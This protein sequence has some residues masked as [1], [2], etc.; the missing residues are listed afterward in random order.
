MTGF[1]VLIRLTGSAFDFSQAQTSGGDLRFAKSDNT[2]L[3]YEIERW[4]PAAGMAEVW[5]KVDTVLGNDNTHAITM[6]WGNPNVADSSNGAAVFDTASGFQGV[7]HLGEAGNTVAKDATING[8]N[9]TL[10]GMTAA[11]SVPGAIG[12]ARNFDGASGYIQMI[13][14]A[15]GKLNF[16]QNGFY[17][18]SAWVCADTLDFGTDSTRAGTI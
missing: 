1:P 6:Y 4:D 3:P 17:A 9:G 2:P 12:I 14:T 13:G 18:V 11:S 5:V 7:W 10:Y 15:A 8:F 16:S